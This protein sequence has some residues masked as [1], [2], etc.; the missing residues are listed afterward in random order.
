ME[1][2]SDWIFYATTNHYLKKIHVREFCGISIS[3]LKS[4]IKFVKCPACL[5]HE[6][7]AGVYNHQVKKHGIPWD[8]GFLSQEQFKWELREEVSTS[9]QIYTYGKL[10]VQLFEDIGY[11]DVTDLSD[12]VPSIK[13][14][15]EVTPML[16]GF[17]HPR[18]SCAVNIAAGLHRAIQPAL[19]P[20]LELSLLKVPPKDDVATIKVWRNDSTDGVLAP[21]WS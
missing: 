12:H 2:Y 15:V 20:R 8:Y 4:I 17:D 6:I 10:N 11:E 3:F 21:I 1:V 19:L 7:E 5:P 9:C 13:T 14:L 18:T 16:C